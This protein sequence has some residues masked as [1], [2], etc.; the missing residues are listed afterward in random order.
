MALPDYQTIML[1]LL[2]FAGDKKEHS[3]QETIDALSE[4][5]GLTEEEKRESSQ[6]LLHLLM[7]RENMLPQ[8]RVD[9]FLLTEKSWDVS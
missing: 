6:L 9:L 2:K 1:P 8:L 5:F 4:E 3:T 7:R